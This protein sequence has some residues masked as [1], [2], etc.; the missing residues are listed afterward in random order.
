[1][2]RVMDNTKAEMMF[3]DPPYGVDYDGGLFNAQKR[4]KLRNDDSVNIFTAFLPI[5]VS[6]VDGP[7]YMWFGESK[8]K[9]IYIALDENHCDIHAQIIWHKTNATY[10]ALNRQYKQRHEPCL[11][12]KPKG[13]TLRWCGPTTESTVWNQD[14]DA[15]N[16]LHPTQK[17]VALPAKAIANHDATT[18]LDL[19]AGSG[20][21]L[22]AAEQLS[23]RCY[24]IE[25]EPSYCQVTIDR[26]EAFTGEKAKKVQP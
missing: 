2:A 20:T 26:W 17:P 11:Y 19:F 22:I 24:A 10:A 9:D 16:D 13:S 6:V 18:V 25:I 14:R 23:R 5:A 7:C 12:F 1:M 8:A 15:I 21:T 4:K 3:T